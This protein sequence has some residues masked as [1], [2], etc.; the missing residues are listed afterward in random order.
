MN[1]NFSPSQAAQGANYAGRAMNAFQSAVNIDDQQP[2]AEGTTFWFRWL[3]RVVAIT[4]GICKYAEIVYQ[5]LHLYLC[6]LL[7]LVAMICGMFG[8]LSI[9]PTCIIAGV[10]MMYVCLS[11][12][13][14]KDDLVVSLSVS[15]ASHWSCS[16]FLS[17]VN[18]C[19]TRNRW[20]N[21]LNN[22]HP[23]K[24]RCSIPCKL[25]GDT[26]SDRVTNPCWF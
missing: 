15:S 21:S 23:G 6:S 25:T 12:L 18:S 9:S 1:F 11:L 16:K 13:R 17:A 10:M 26:Q 2:Q 19:N 20:H 24:R 14:T 4:T 5:S 22:V 3:I 7:S 8:A